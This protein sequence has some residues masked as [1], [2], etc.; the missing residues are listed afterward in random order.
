MINKKL[1]VNI[2]PRG[3]FLA[4]TLLSALAVSGCGDKN[5]REFMRGC[6]SGGATTAI[7]GCIWD[8]LKTKYTHGELEKM[9]QQYGYV[10]PR[11]MDNM[12]S[13]AQQCRK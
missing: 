2:T 5:E 6:K 3:A 1:I 9:N 13:A 10:P 12:L 11:F 7:C 8:D 4:F